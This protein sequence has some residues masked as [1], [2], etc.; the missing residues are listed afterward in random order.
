METINVITVQKDALD[1]ADVRDVDMNELLFSI[2]KHTGLNLETMLGF[3]DIFKSYRRPPATTDITDIIINYM[4]TRPNLNLSVTAVL[5]IKAH[6]K[7]TWD[8]YLPKVVPSETIRMELPRR[9]NINAVPSN[10]KFILPKKQFL[11]IQSINDVRVINRDALKQLYVKLLEPRL[12]A[13]TSLNSIN[14]KKFIKKTHLTPKIPYISTPFI[15]KLLT[16]GIVLNPKCVSTEQYIGNII[17]LDLKPLFT[18]YIKNKDDNIEGKEWTLYYSGYI[19]KQQ[20]IKLDKLKTE[21]TTYRNT[22]LN[23]IRRY[24][25]LININIDKTKTI[26][27]ILK[28]SLNKKERDYV[29]SLYESQKQL[30]TGVQQNPCP[31][32]N[33]CFKL[34]NTTLSEYNFKKVTS[35]IK[36]NS[37]K[38]KYLTCKNCTFNLICPHVI[39]LLR[40]QLSNAEPREILDSM[41]P[42][43]D[44]GISAFDHFCKI[45]HEEIPKHSDYEF[46]EERYIIGYEV[47][48]KKLWVDILTT[49]NTLKFAPLVNLYDFAVTVANV[50]L[51]TIITS[52]NI[53]VQNEM[54]R[55]NKTDEISNTLD[56]YTWLYLY[57]YI[58]HMIKNNISNPDPRYIRITLSEDVKG[59]K[60]S[61]YG[62]ALI[63]R[64]ETKHRGLLAHNKEINIAE[65]FKQIFSEMALLDIP[66]YIERLFSREKEVYDFL[67]ANTYY[68]YS[69]RIAQLT[70]FIS[71]DEKTTTSEYESIVEK[72][73]NKN[74]LDIIKLGTSE[75]LKLIDFP[76]NTS[77]GIYIKTYN[78]YKK[79]FL[80]SDK[81]EFTELLE[82]DKKA[83]R[84][85]LFRWYIPTKKTKA[86]DVYKPRVHSNDYKLTAIID[87]N[88]YP[89]KWDILVLKDGKEL[90]VGTG[91]DKQNAIID[92]KSSK[93]NLLKSQTYK[94]D[95]E[96]T[97][98]N[99]IKVETIDS[100]YQHYSVLCP[101]TGLHVFDPTS[102]I[103]ICT[104]C[105]FN[106]KHINEDNDYYKKYY[107]VF[108][109]D[110]LIPQIITQSPQ[111]KLVFVPK[112]WVFNK[113]SIIEVSEM[114]NIPQ[115]IFYYIG[116]MHTV[117]YANLIIG[118]VPPEYPKPTNIQDTK[119]HITKGHILNTISL[120]NMVKYGVNEDPAFQNMNITSGIYKDLPL[121]IYTE[122]INRVD[123]LYHVK[124]DPHEAFLMLIQTL[125]DFIMSVV[126]L[127]KIGDSYAKNLAIYLINNALKAEYLNCMP[128]NPNYALLKK[129]KETDNV[130][131]DQEFQEEYEDEDIKLFVNEADYTGYNDTLNHD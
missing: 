64:F 94:N 5:D 53:I 87:E 88:G 35:Y 71:I 99:Y 116:S 70:K 25:P 104:K 117:T 14:L 90:K 128:V 101:E 78:I 52:K 69:L 68:K 115:I 118:K 112:T 39:D 7:N 102:P 9:Y 44:K 20:G 38:T 13:Y 100:F 72:L 60:V 1:L 45:C 126:R 29:L 62:E 83:H 36:D 41:E 92:Y 12:P 17:S 4:L 93:T 79:W 63:K 16:Y 46:Q 10:K 129:R 125:C 77:S 98:K 24:Y 131:Y 23:I 105:A 80:G 127:K 11:D 50:L 89:Y 121:D 108:K 34:R 96:K 42:Y 6:G 91:I 8:Y 33:L 123:D 81:S 74:I 120:Y 109:K 61:D 49:Y 3:I 95:L 97:Y 51:P 57:S 54:N 30:K 84:Y 28:E 119:I 76:L 43:I 75:I 15:K 58:L 122:Y 66:F 103:P 2:S 21:E 40:L 19:K 26:H 73:V 82:E 86:E 55:Y 124:M 18:S 114:L 65:V 85:E 113:A 27:K 111:S 59:R 56:I 107:E 31:H 48:R 110:M 47:F 37:V 67:M 130:V 106:K 32:V 22:L